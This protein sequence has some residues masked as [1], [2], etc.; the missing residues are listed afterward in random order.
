MS[1]WDSIEIDW[2][3]ANSV[4]AKQTASFQLL[5]QIGKTLDASIVGE[6]VRSHSGVTGTVLVFVACHANPDG[7]Y[8]WIAPGEEVEADPV[9]IAMRDLMLV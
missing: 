9:R 3:E 2:F 6:K 8:V 4:E 5:L 7:D 1:V